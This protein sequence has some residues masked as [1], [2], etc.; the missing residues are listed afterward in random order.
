MIIRRLLRDLIQ[1]LGLSL[2]VIHQVSSTSFQTILLLHLVELIYGLVE[3]LLDLRK[4]LGF[5]LF[6]HTFKRAEFAII[7]VFVLRLCVIRLLV[8]LD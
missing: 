5:I 6:I 2:L 3:L 8:F 1:L 7:I 4:L